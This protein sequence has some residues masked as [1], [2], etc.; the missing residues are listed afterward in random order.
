MTDTG[1]E[2]RWWNRTDPELGLLGFFTKADRDAFSS[3]RAGPFRRVV[4]RDGRTVLQNED[5]RG[6]VRRMAHDAGV[7]P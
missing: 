1:M 3:G 2:W 6:M 5:F 4:A 7:G